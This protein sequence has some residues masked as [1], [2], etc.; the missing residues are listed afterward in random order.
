MSRI[1]EDL[2]SRDFYTTKPR[3]GSTVILTILIVIIVLL[4]LYIVIIIASRI[5]RKCKVAPNAPTSPQAGYLSN[6]SFRVSWNPVL[7]ADS[8][9]VY[10]GQTASFSR[11]QSVNVTTSK[12]ASAD[13]IGLPTN[14]TYYIYVSAKNNCGESLNST[15]ITFVNVQS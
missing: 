10:V 3:N 11:V 5:P 15:Q 1:L 4:V 8:Y 6:K 9:V 14:N 13:V 2:T 12:R 7:G